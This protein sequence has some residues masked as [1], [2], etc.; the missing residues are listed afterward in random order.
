MNNDKG[1]AH[2][3]GYALS[4]CLVWGNDSFNGG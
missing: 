3:L 4:A 2:F 1:V